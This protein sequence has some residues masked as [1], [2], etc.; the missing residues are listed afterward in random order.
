MPRNSAWKNTVIILAIISLNACSTFQ[1]KPSAVSS[2]PTVQT[3]PADKD[4][5]R[6]VSDITAGRDEEALKLFNAA[7]K[8]YPDFA[9]P[10]I[11]VGLIETRRGNLHAAE[12]A[13]LHATAL[14]PQQPEIYNGLGIVYRRMGRFGDAETAYLKALQ[15]APDYANAQLN[16]GILYD[17]YLDKLGAALDHYQRYQAISGGDNKMVKN[18]IID[19]KQRLAKDMGATK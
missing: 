9:A 18:W 5:R 7:A 15:L 6:A 11:N 19:V 10:Y 3:A 12:T 17:L 14:A 2:R 8:E 16:I 1:Y 4:Y 13:L